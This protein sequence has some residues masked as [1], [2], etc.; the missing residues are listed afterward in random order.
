LSSLFLYSSDFILIL[1]YSPFPYSSD[2]NFY[3]IEAGLIKKEYIAK[4]VGSFPEGEV[5]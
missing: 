5:I 2:A 3:Q 4:V 1:A